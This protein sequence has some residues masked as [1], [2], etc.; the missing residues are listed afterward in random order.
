MGF[1][2]IIRKFLE[3]AFVLLPALLILWISYLWRGFQL[4]DALIYLRYIKNYQEGYGLVYNPG[5]KFNGLTSPLFTYV[6]LAASRLVSNLQVL[7]VMVSAIFLMGAAYIGGALFTRTRYGA[8]LSSCVIGVFGYFY[9]TFGM[10]TSLFLFLI[11][12]SLYLF[13]H[14][15][16]YFFVALALLVIT[17]SEGVFLAVPLVVDFLFKK[18]RLPSWRITFL[19]LSVFVAPYIFNYF[20][21]GE[22]LA[23]TGSAKVGQGKS[24][25]GGRA[26]FFS[27]PG[28]LLI[29]P[30]QVNATSRWA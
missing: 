15:S 28:T 24:G 5:E 21:Y 18:K 30:S 13:K 10:E 9:T 7:T 11:A 26:G 29:G 25:F 17:R 3:C 22:F 12:L 19:A 1:G 16:E 4:D 6:M 14:D 27:T 20:Y 8:L 23:V 2:M